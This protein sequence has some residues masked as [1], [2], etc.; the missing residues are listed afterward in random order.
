[1][2][3]LVR[4]LGKSGCGV[5]RS[6][7][8]NGAPH[9]SSLCWKKEPQPHCARTHAGVRP[10]GSGRR[11]R[12]QATLCRSVGGAWHHCMFASARWGVMRS[13][14]VR[15]PGTTVL[16]RTHCWS[17]SVRAA[18]YL[19]RKARK[20][21]KARVGAV[22]VARSP[23]QPSGRAAV[24]ARRAESARPLLLP[25]PQLAQLRQWEPDSRRL[26]SLPA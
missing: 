2:P 23:A 15:S 25:R 8:S 22:A 3:D 4:R 16:S 13:V 9:W 24:P 10:G 19:A 5:G 21:R 1:M 17:P 7:T 12:L 20:A 6:R 26:R 14:G 11:S 18:S